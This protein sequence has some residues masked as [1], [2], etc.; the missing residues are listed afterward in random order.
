LAVDQADLNSIRPGQTVRIKLDAFADEVI[1]AM[2]ESEED[3]SR[4]PMKYMPQSM[5]VQGGGKVAARTDSSGAPRPLSATYQVTVK[6][7]EDAMKFKIGQRGR[8][9]VAADP[10]TLGQR[11][12]RAITSTFHFEL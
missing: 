10:R 4:E 3:I 6:L 8:A 11:L 7:P 2:I 12:W 5:T 1:E 9:K